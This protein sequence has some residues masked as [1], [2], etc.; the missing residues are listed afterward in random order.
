MERNKEDESGMEKKE[1]EMVIYK[2]SLRDSSV[3]EPD[4]SLADDLNDVVNNNVDILNDVIEKSID[5]NPTANNDEEPANDENRDEVEKQNCEEVSG[6]DGV[7]NNMENETEETSLEEQK[8]LKDVKDNQSHILETKSPMHQDNENTF[9][10]K[11]ATQDDENM[12][13]TIVEDD[14]GKF[15]T[16]NVDANIENVDV[17]TL[18]TP[19]NNKKKKCEK[20]SKKKAN[21]KNNILKLKRPP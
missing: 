17:E 8:M 1:S 19:T 11:N 6:E 9:S 14:I 3:E 13:N 18:S 21:K 20:K 4:V 7:Q 15:V 16:N 2:G 12:V 10:E 5:P